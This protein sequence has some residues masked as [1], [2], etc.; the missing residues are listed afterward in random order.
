MAKLTASAERALSIIAHLSMASRLDKNVLGMT[1]LLEFYKKQMSRQ[2]MEVFERFDEL[3][4][5]AARDLG[6]MLEQD[7]KAKDGQ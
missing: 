4:K 7:L 1:G 6:K 3:C 5:Q 2:D